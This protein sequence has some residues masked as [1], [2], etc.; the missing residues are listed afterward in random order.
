[1]S[2]ACECEIVNGASVTWIHQTQPPHHG[3]VI[4]VKRVLHHPHKARSLAKSH[5]LRTERRA[6]V[7]IRLWFTAFRPAETFLFS[8]NNRSPLWYYFVT[9]PFNGS[10]VVWGILAMHWSHLTINLR[11]ASRHSYDNIPQLTLVSVSWEPDQLH[12]TLT[13]Y[14]WF[15]ATDEPSTRGRLTETRY[16][17][18]LTFWE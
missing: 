8:P 1:M 16:V 5:P 14:H 12:S 13:T 3:Q 17:L 9:L 7:T 11:S 10:F 4:N 18:I 15:T 6:P 2:R